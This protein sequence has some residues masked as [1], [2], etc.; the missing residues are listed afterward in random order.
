MPWEF[1]EF[2]QSLSAAN[3]NLWIN[4]N[5]G[6]VMRIYRLKSRLFHPIHRNYPVRI[7]D[8]EAKRISVIWW[9][10]PR[11]WERA[12]QEDQWFHGQIPP[13]PPVTGQ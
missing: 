9:S 8:L 11:G 10:S 6:W 5:G 2:N 1:P 12:L 4:L 7:E 13:Q 3:N